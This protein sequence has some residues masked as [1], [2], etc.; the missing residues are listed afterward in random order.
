MIPADSQH[1]GSP[2][3]TRG[4]WHVAENALASGGSRLGRFLVF[5]ERVRPGY[6]ASI[7]EERFGVVI[8]GGGQAGLAVSHELTA[9]GVDHVILERGRVAQTWRD[10]WDSFCLVTPNWSVQL[11]GGAYAGD[12]PDG[13]MG[14][15]DIVRHLEAGRG[16]PILLQP[17]ELSRPAPT[18]AVDG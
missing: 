9:L 8:V 2:R 17:F 6:A 11:P 14:R 5:V 4:R 16:V 10:R 1:R 7:M 3:Y 15:E 18:L 12:D 13:F